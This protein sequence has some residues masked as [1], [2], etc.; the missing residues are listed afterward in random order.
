MI[1]IFVLG[2]PIGQVEKKDSAA[3]IEMA[4]IRKF[5]RQV[6]FEAFN[7][8]KV[9]VNATSNDVGIEVVPKTEETTLTFKTEPL[10][11]PYNMYY[12]IEE[13]MNS[14]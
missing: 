2:F 4:P 11:W 3:Q 12:T 7:Y 5:T 8:S 9:V 13:H 6:D 1:N 10:R 14:V